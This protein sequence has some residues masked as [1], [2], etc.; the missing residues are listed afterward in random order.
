[1]LLRIYGA[2]SLTRNLIYFTMHPIRPK[3]TPPP[4]APAP[5]LSFKTNLVNLTKYPIRIRV[6][7]RTPSSS[8]Q[9]WCRNW[10]WPLTGS[11]CLLVR[12]HPL[13]PSRLRRPR[14]PTMAPASS[15]TPWRTLTRSRKSSRVSRPHSLKS[16]SLVCDTHTHH[17][18]SEHFS[19][20]SRQYVS[21]AAG[22][23]FVGTYSQLFG[24]FL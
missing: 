9:C 15:V 22:F 7:S 16:V 13:P 20:L 10:A 24:S 4:P 17:P 11:W 21:Y 1:M 12:L 18:C 5:A 19:S 2:L 3:R 8:R 23:I 14:P 6:S